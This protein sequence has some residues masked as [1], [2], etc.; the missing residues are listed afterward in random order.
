M[1]YNILNMVTTFFL[2]RS[3]KSIERSEINPTFALEKS[4]TNDRVQYTIPKHTW[5]I[6]ILKRL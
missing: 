5:N 4:L 3:T 1:R 2:G 6:L